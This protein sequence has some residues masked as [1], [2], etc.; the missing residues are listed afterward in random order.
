M[1]TVEKVLH[2]FLLDGIVDSKPGKNWDGDI[3]AKF[4]DGNAYTGSF[5]KGYMDGEG[6]YFWKTPETRYAG[7]FQHNKINGSGKYSWKDGSSYVG[8]VKDSLRHGHGR[9]QFN[10]GPVYEGDWKDSVRQGNGILYF[11]GDT[12]SLYEGDWHQSSKTGKGK[13]LYPSGSYYIGEWKDNIKNG[14]GKMVWKYSE[15]HQIYDGSWQNGKP[16]GIGTYYWLYPTDPDESV[17]K[18]ARRNYYEGEWVEGKR[19]GSGTF[20]YSDGTIYT[21]EWKENKKHGKGTFIDTNG[22][23]FTGNFT[24]DKQDFIDRT[25]EPT[26]GP[27]LF[28]DDLKIQNTSKEYQQLQALLFRYY[29]KLKEIYVY[30]SNIPNNTSDESLYLNNL[31]FSQLLA[32]AEIVSVE[33]DTGKLPSIIIML[34]ID[35]ATLI[36]KINSALQQRATNGILNLTPEVKI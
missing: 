5:K 17:I 25:A 21:G 16:H 15:V 10:K 33:C 32:D 30:Y 1:S 23:A 4:K 11:N 3:R 27:V 22:N 36:E 20:F 14:Q 18:K 6:E 9:F 2:E 31:Q 8:D 13:M 19:G 26:T 24:E 7:Q 12:S 29:N 35:I 28:L 34:N